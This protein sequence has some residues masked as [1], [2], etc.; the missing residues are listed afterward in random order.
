MTTPTTVQVRFQFRADTAANWTTI[1]PVLLANELGRE[2][3]TGKIKIGDGTTAWS[4]LAYQGW[5]SLTYP[6]VNADIDAAAAIDHSKLADITAGSVLLGNASNVPTATALS[7]DVTVN[8][9]GVTAIGSGVIVDA[10]VSATAEIAVSKLANGTANQILTTD[11][12]DVSW[13]DSPTIAG[14][15]IIS[16]N[17]TVNGTETIINVDTL[18]VEDKTIEMGNVTTPTDLTADGGG[19]VLKGA[20]DKTILWV[21]STDSWTSSENVDLASGKTYKIAG[22]DVLSATTLGSAVVNSSLTSVGNLTDLT[23]DTDTLVVDAT[24]NRVG[25]GVASPATDLHIQGAGASVIRLEN[26]NGVAYTDIRQNQTGEYLEISPSSSSNQSFVVNRPD[27]SEALRIDSSGRLLVGSSTVLDTEGIKPSV[28]SAQAGNEAGF[29]AFRYSDDTPG[30]IIHL[31]KSRGTTVGTNALVQANDVLGEIRFTGADGANEILSA[32]IRTL[33]DGTPAYAATALV[34]STDYRI[35]TVGTTDFTAIGAAD[36]NVGTV[37]TATGPGTGTGTAILNAGNM[38][39][40]LEIRTRADGAASPTTRMTIDSSGNVAIDTDTLYV[41]ATNDFVGVGTASP[42]AELH[43]ASTTQPTIKIEDSDNGFDPVELGATN[44]GR[45]FTFVTN[46]DY[47]FNNA[48]STYM[49]IDSSGRLLV[50]TSSS[51]TGGT[52]D[53]IQASHVSGSNIILNRQVAAAGSTGD[54]IGGI[55][56]YS[57]AGSASEEHARIWCQADNNTDSGDKPGRLVFSTTADGAASPT[58]RMRIDSSGNVGIGA[59]TISSLLHLQSSDATAFDATATDGQV[60]VGPTIYLENPANANNTVGGQIVFGMRGTEEQARISATGGTSPQLVFTTADAQRMVIDSSGNVGIGTTTATA[61]SGSTALEVQG[62]SGAEIVIGTTDTTATAG[63]LFGGIAFKSVDANGTP[64]HYSG[65]Q[66]RAEDTFGGATLN[67][68]VGRD[69]YEDNDPRFVIE[70]P[71]SVTGEA[72]R[73]DSS[74]RLLVNTT[75]ART[76][77]YNASTTAEPLLQVESAS[78][79]RIGIISSSTTSG[80]GGQLI[81]AHQVSGAVGGNTLVASGANT[82]LISFQGS[83]GAQFVET[84]RITSEVDGT[85]GADDM[86]GRLVFSTTADGASSPT[87]RMR[88]EESGRLNLFTNTN[89]VVRSVRTGASESAFVVQ[90]ASTST[91]TGTTELVVYADGDVENTNNRYTQ[92]SDERFKENIVDASSQWDD[93]KA[94]RVRNFNFKEET[95]RNTHT[96]LGVVAQEIELTSPGLVIERKDPDTDETHKSVAYSVLYMKA[97]KALQEAMERI[98]QLEAKVAALEGN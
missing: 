95:G 65:I 36:N 7:G 21:D 30:P 60:G 93:I 86:P 43:I 10:D 68:Y 8:S 76:N 89:L 69:N 33:V 83:D 19:I 40:R 41:D 26:G 1:D 81:L 74:G 84:A 20:T 44:G 31:F 53:I 32:Q 29:G 13:T 62:T 46:Q 51:V 23:V 12:T 97:V 64:P 94:V 67:F 52:A 34:A 78:Q 9:S 38:P 17:L 3:D 88:L 91:L 70:G 27:G 85:P 18:Q 79:P 87:E 4:S 28:Q 37:F 57:Y 73:I 11:G 90:S 82:G 35:V 16:G 15:V 56:F 55:R 2:T 98:E 71:Q 42:T 75:S 66:A 80:F 96:Q 50:G 72:L 54:Y 5:S 49:T 6:L 14:N 59:T 61:V 92:L 47:Y 39:G 48:S 22:T 58:E 45:D 24:N 25:I 63:D 77:F